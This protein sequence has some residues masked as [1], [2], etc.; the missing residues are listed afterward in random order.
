MKIYKFSVWGWENNSHELLSNEKEY[1]ESEYHDIC[2]Q[3]YAEESFNAQNVIRTQ[4]KN[5]NVEANEDYIDMYR[6]AETIY[7][8][9]LDR[10]V[11][12]YGFKI[13]VSDIN[14][15][16]NEDESFLDDDDDDDR[17]TTGQISLVR[18]KY[19]GFIRV[20]KLKRILNEN[21]KNNT[22]R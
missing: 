10:L 16:V 5:D 2:A 9:V 15:I 18:E 22:N 3:L 4:Y 21:I 1:T 20:E 12:D 13:I 14:F 7:N 19:K 17:V 8:P 11:K 6:Y